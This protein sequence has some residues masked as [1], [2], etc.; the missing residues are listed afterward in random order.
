VIQALGVVTP[1]PPYQGQQQQQQQQQQER[2][3]QCQFLQG[4]L[5]VF[6]A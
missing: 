1:Q 3:Q 5:A 4:I 2:Q 6:A